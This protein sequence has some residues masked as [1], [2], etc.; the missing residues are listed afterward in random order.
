[1]RYITLIFSVCAL[2]LHT[3]AE[4]TITSFPPSAW[5][6]DESV[7]ND[8]LGISWYHNENFEDQFL[9]SGLTIAAENNPA[10]T[11]LPLED[12]T[13][14]FSNAVWDGTT[15]YVPTVRDTGNVL[16]P[17]T[18]GFP[19]GV[20]SAGFGLGDI[21]TPVELW[22]NGFY[23]ELINDNSNFDPSV[24]NTRDIYYRIDALPG[25]IITSVALIPVGTGSGDGIFID[26]VA[27]ACD[28]PLDGDA[29]RDGRVDV[30]DI[31]YV[32]FR[33]GNVAGSCP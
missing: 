7:M 12:L 27:F 22:V 14:E 17:I 30:N 2:T 28:G 15:A 31:S 10:A 4:V 29:N 25:D 13:S 16:L 1:M 26:H 9:I 32:L 20:V 33:L 11:L 21:E 3:N 23:K 6:A 24:D 5:N 18:F 19:G 8:N